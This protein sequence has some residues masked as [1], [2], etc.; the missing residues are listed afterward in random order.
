M[1]WSAIFLLRFAYNFFFFCIFAFFCCWF[2]F[3]PF[4]EFACLCAHPIFTP[5]FH[6][7]PFNYVLFVYCFIFSH[8][9]RCPLFFH[10]LTLCRSYFSWTSGKKL[11]KIFIG[12]YRILFFHIF[13]FFSRS[14]GN[15]FFGF[16]FEAFFSFSFLLGDIFSPLPFNYLTLKKWCWWWTPQ[17]NKNKLC[18]APSPL[19]THPDSLWNCVTHSSHFV[20]ITRIGSRTLART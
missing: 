15:I 9:H 5:F 7:S 4:L 2:G 18:R 1:C 19:L 17:S 14:N 8:F 10:S 3:R 12:H 20:H 6:L 13:F 11:L 16:Q